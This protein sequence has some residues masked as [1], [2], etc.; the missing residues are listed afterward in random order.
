MIKGDS[1]P[2]QL[3]KVIA[4]IE[5]E[6]MTNKGIFIA[7]VIIGLWASSLT[8]LFSLDTSKIQ[9]LLIVLAIIWQKFLYTGLFITAHDAMHG[10]VFAKNPQINAWIG[11]TSVILYALFSYKNL[12]EKHCLHHQYPGTEN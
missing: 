1:T 9:I 5:T 10:I 6:N 8:V 3:T 7:F 12:I 2:L 11:K 4:A